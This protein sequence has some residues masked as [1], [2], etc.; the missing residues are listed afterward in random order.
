[1]N[2]N[3]I[4]NEITTRVDFAIAD[5]NTYLYAKCQPTLEADMNQVSIGGGN[6]NILL[7][8]VSVLDLLAQVNALV[9]GTEAD[10]W[11]AKELLQI[12]EERKKI[13]KK[14]QRYFNVPKIGDF[15]NTGKERFLKLLSQTA[16][17]TGLT[18]EQAKEIYEIR[19]KIVHCFSPKIRPAAALPIMPGRDFA[20]LIKSY[21]SIPVFCQTTDNRTGIDSNAL[22]HKLG[23]ISLYVI[24]K[25]EKSTDDKISQIAQ[26]FENN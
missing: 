17:L 21:I 6:F 24:R 11:Q 15:K 7:A 16:S 19:N 8:S 22:S 12:K 1:M 2:K 10:F 23:V 3:D 18:T 9:D 25:I 26:W 4:V 5:S 13:T 20:S 14:F